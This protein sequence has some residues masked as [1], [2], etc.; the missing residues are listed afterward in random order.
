MR[1]YP[2]FSWPYQSNASSDC[3][4]VFGRPGPERASSNSCFGKWVG[5]VIRKL[6]QATRLTS[7]DARRTGSLARFQTVANGITPVRWGDAAHPAT[8]AQRSVM[9]TVP[10]AMGVVAMS[11]VT[12]TFGY[13]RRRQSFDR[14]IDHRNEPL[15]DE[16]VARRLSQNPPWVN[17]TPIATSHFAALPE[18]ELARRPNRKIPI[19]KLLS[20][21]TAPIL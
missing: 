21:K 11:C 12:G 17:Q 13:S 19:R 3:R 16:S 7:C 10:I 8:N 14:P 6:G 1:L 9:N 18:G 20:S 15:A 4:A 2:M 5:T